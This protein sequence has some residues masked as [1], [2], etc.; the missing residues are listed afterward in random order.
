LRILLY[1]DQGEAVPQEYLRFIVC[2]KM[3]WD[4]Y[5]F[6][7][8]PDFFVEEVLICMQAENKYRE[9]KNNK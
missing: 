6:M 8:Q 3:G 7:Q 4:Y 1:P 2:K 9:A 5:T